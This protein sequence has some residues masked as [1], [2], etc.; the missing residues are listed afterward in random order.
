[1]TIAAAIVFGVVSIAFAVRKGGSDRRWLELGLWTMAVVTAVVSLAEPIWLEESGPRALGRG[2]AV[3]AWA[4]GPLWL[5][6]GAVL[7]RQGLTEALSTLVVGLAVGGCA[8]LMAALAASRERAK[9]WTYSIGAVVG[10]LGVMA[11]ALGGQG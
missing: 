10:S 1:M 11:V 6:A 3:F 2:W 8:C 7:M 9:L 4:Q 5:A